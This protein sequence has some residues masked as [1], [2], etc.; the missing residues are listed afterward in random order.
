MKVLRVIAT[1]VG[2]GLIAGFVGAVAM[3]IA[4]TLEMKLRKRPPSSAPA[5]AAGKVLGIQPRDEKGKRRFSNRRPLRVR[6]RVGTRARGDPGGVLRRRPRGARRSRSR[7]RTSPSCGAWAS[8]CCPRLASPS[9][10][11]AG[12]R[13][14]SRSTP[15]ITASTPPPRT[16][17]TACW[18]GP[19]HAVHADALAARGGHGGDH[20]LAHG[21][22][23][24]AGGA[25]Q[26]PVRLAARER[27][28]DGG[29]GADRRQAAAHAEPHGADRAR[30]ARRQRRGRRPGDARRAGPGPRRGRRRAGAWARRPRFS[31]RSRACACGGR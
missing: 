6:Q 12:A 9:R 13:R 14:R 1:E 17:R 11:G 3:T 4:S 30:A 22:G 26:R 24:G 10:S 19:S 27:V 5:D 7:W 2:R 31:A 18:G 29:A 21:A 23:A 25:A 8:P 16:A 28:P 20:R 15:S